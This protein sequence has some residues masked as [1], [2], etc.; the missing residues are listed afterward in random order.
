M[1]WI[2]D[3]PWGNLPSIWRSEDGTFRFKIRYETDSRRYM[4][5]MCNTPGFGEVDLGRGDTLEEAE[6]FC[7]WVN[8]A[9][10][11]KLVAVC[12][13]MNSQGVQ[14]SPPV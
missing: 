8:R 13:G 12:I 4:S 2:K 3:E 14:D 9:Y 10:E 6:R 1:T 11:P 5:T 7:E